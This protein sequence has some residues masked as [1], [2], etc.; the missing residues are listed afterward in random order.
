MKVTT[1]AIKV[2]RW[3]SVVLV[4]GAL[5]WTYSVFPQMVAVDFSD[6]GLAEIYLAK[7]HIFYIVMALFLVNNVLIARFAKLVSNADPMHLPI[8]KKRIWA[9]HREELNEHLVNWF[10]C[11][12]AAINTVIGFSL[13]SLATINST[14]YKVDVFDFSWLYYIGVALLVIVLLLPLRLL[15]T[16]VPEDRL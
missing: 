15:S 6:S 9:Q 12:V 7:E 4:I 10:N 14:N 2:W 16:P 5:I 11:L 1:F 13:F 8:P 3:L